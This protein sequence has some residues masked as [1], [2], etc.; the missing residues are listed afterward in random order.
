MN[1]SLLGNIRKYASLKNINYVLFGITC[2]AF[3]Y[4]VGFGS[5]AALFGDGQE[6]L[7]MQEAF[8]NHLSP[9]IRPVDLEKS[10]QIL[11]ANGD[12]VPDGYLNG[13]KNFLLNNPE[14]GQQYWGA[15]IAKNGKAYCYHFWMYSLSCLPVELFLKVFHLNQ[16]KSFQITNLL[17]LFLVIWYLFFKSKLSESRKLIAGVLFLF[18][19]NIW[20]IIRTHPEI[21]LLVSSFF[22]L[23]VI[24]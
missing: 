6:Y 12:K 15:F 19:G 13:L 1:L 9:D 22:S 21:F 14:P 24:I 2:L 11:Y 7:Y 8:A 10:Q 4:I 23:V 5:K 16:L 18:S 20:Y 3:L 17:F